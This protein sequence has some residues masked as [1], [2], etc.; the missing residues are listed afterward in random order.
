MYRYLGGPAFDGIV[1]S[2]IEPGSSVLDIGC[3]PGMLIF[4]LLK[5]Q[6]CSRAVGIDLSSRMIE[7]AN[8]EKQRRGFEN[9]E[10]R[11]MNAVNLSQV[12]RERFDYAVTSFVLHELPEELRHSVLDQMTAVGK[13]L[14]IVE[15]MAN[16]SRTMGFLNWLTE[17]LAGPAH[18]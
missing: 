7:Y 9:V 4:D 14:I 1:M 5:S 10:F 16:Q 8:R 2:L 18:L 11:H 12:I 6:K 17:S 15:Y 3:G 13:T